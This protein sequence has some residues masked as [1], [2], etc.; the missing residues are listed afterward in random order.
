[1][2]QKQERHAIYVNSALA[3]VAELTAS[4]KPY[5]EAYEISKKKAAEAASSWADIAR[6]GNALASSFGV[7]FPPLT[8]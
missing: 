6:S 2:K 4:G 8:K 5:N 3:A 1:M 7:N